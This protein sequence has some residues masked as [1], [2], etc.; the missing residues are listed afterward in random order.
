MRNRKIFRVAL[1]LMLAIA[2]AYPLLLW[3]RQ[4]CRLTGLSTS[5]KRILCTATGSG[6]SVNCF[7]GN[8]I[9]AGL[10]FACR[11]RPS[12]L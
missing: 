4:P 10:A 3:G 1:T 6:E 11:P 12:P 2:V 7:F 9:A 5:T 8:E